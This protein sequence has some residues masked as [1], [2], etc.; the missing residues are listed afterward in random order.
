MV[1]VSPILLQV[2]GLLA[3]CG[4]TTA[5]L[6]SLGLPAPESA[7]PGNSNFRLLY[8]HHELVLGGAVKGLKE[9]VRNL[10]VLPYKSFMYGIK[11]GMPYGYQIPDGI[12]QKI[13]ESDDSRL[14]DEPVREFV[15]KTVKQLRKPILNAVTSRIEAGEMTDGLRSFTTNEL[16]NA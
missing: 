5:L 3:R 1:Q 7:E 9:G 16:L 12:L 11:A 4:K 10:L 15:L 2:S 6:K 8:I 13:E 14:S